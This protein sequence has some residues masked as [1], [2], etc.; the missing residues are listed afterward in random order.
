MTVEV[1][2][3]VAAMGEAMAAAVTAEER[4]ERVEAKVVVARAVGERVGGPG[5]EGGGG[6]SDGGGGEGTGGGGDGGG[7]EGS[8][9][10]AGPMRSTKPNTSHTGLPAPLASICVVGCRLRAI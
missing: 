6:E 1:A 8:S 9:P 3:A 5:G 7:G 2:R 4:V 10:C